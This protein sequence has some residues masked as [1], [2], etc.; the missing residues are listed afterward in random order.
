MYRSIIINHLQ[1]G[2]SLNNNIACIYVYF[3]YKKQKT[4]TLL[5]LLSTLLVQLLRSRTGFCDKVKEI[6]A[7]YEQKK[8]YPTTDN[9]IDMLK[10]QMQSF[11]RVYI[12]VDALDECLDDFKYRT[13]SYF[14]D[15]CQK[16]PHNAHILFTSRP[17]TDLPERIN[18]S[19]KLEIVANSG[20][21][22]QYLQKSINSHPG[23]REIIRTEQ[24]TDS[25]FQTRVLDTVVSRSRGM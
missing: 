21:M 8:H 6:H 12:I 20:D 24:K 5:G 17:G 19:C 2:Y 16:L 25:Q 23:L 18:S 15:A 7:A 3:D 10:C 9:Y 1:T 22:K 14:L 13:L 11:S 4:Q